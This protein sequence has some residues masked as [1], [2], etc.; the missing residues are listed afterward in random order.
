MIDASAV[1][2]CLWLTIW[3]KIIESIILYVD[4]GSD[5]EHNELYL[6]SIM[7]Q[8]VQQLKEVYK[9]KTRQILNESGITTALSDMVE[10][11]R[12]QDN[13]VKAKLEILSRTISNLFSVSNK[14]SYFVGAGCCAP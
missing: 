8:T 9:E 7:Q 13:I 10:H 1:A 11:Y 4:F 14:Q 3:Q 2:E 12:E 6:I 5:D